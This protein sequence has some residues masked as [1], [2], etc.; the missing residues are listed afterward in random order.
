[1]ISFNSFWFLIPISLL[2]SFLLYI[3]G[4]LYGHDDIILFSLCAM[5]IC[6]VLQA[7]VVFNDLKYKKRSFVSLSV[8]F[9]C[10]VFSCISLW[11]YPYIYRT[12]EKIS[13]NI[14]DTDTTYLDVVDYYS[15]VTPLYL[16]SLSWLTIQEGEYGMYY[17]VFCH[18]KKEDVKVSF[19]V[20]ALDEP[21]NMFYNN[22]ILINQC[23]NDSILIKDSFIVNTGM[24]RNRIPSNFDI[25]IEG[26][27]NNI[28]SNT[29]RKK[30]MLHRW[31]R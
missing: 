4:C 15:D 18:P 26:C 29:Y 1:M 28:E 7:L 27:N 21:S 13:F 23:E 2:V 22:E 31:R 24:E 25:R 5:F 30:F 19:T 17:F 20:Y 12:S 16:D 11:L 10:V 14:V 8:L 9:T 6:V 3:W